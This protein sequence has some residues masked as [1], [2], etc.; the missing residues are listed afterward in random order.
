MPSPELSPPGASREPEQ[1]AE[2]AAQVTGPAQAAPVATPSGPAGDASSTVEAEAEGKAAAA[3]PPAA[4][5]FIYPPPPSF[6]ENLPP[7]AG[8]LRPPA[9]HAAA[10]AAVAPSRRKQTPER[11]SGALPGT[12]PGNLPPASFYP[13]TAFGPAAPPGFPPTT[14]P[15]RPGSR[16]PLW[17]IL[18]VFGIVLVVSLSLCGWSLYRIYD[19][20][21]QQYNGIMG[22]IQDYYGDIQR[23]DY[24]HAFD[25]LQLSGPQAGLTREQFIQQAEALD[26][27]YGPVNSYTIIGVP[28]ANVPQNGSLPT[29]Y[30]VQVQVTRSHQ[31]YNVFLTVQE[32]QGTWKITDFD[33]I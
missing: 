32:L 23:Q 31:S 22:L 12:F 19:S 3:S 11:P 20:F 27:Q 2:Q 14:P 7:D 24:T 29:S 8:Q 21:Q 28:S 17:I 4:S 15:V 13:G 6:Y 1:Q 16:R 5:E 26:R 10:P 30:S 25:D 33:R 18:S 9:P